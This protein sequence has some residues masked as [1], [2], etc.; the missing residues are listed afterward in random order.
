MIEDIF[1]DSESPLSAF[2]RDPEGV[3]MNRKAGFI[4]NAKEYAGAPAAAALAKAGWDVFC[5]DDSFAS[6]DM[7]AAYERDN[8]G[9]YAAAAQDAAAFISEG[10]ERFG[11]IDA[12]ISNDIPKGT[13]L[14][15]GRTAG[16]ASLESSDLL[17]E[18]EKH[19]DSLVVEPV[20]LLQAALPMM[21]AARAGSIV[22]ITSGAPLRTPAMGG[23]HGYTAA[24]AA[25][26]MLAKSLAGE[27]ARYNIQ[28]NAVAPFLVYSETFFPSELG[29]EDPKFASFVK[30]LVPMQRFGAPE[31]IGTLIYQLASGDMSFVSGQV[32]AFSGAGC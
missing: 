9:R 12:L 24:R 18:F 32:I 29:A 11:R 19:L 17:E 27:L 10:F 30:K 5:H 2:H 15:K 31:E 6:P 3:K 16:T 20:R 23:P 14:L 4:T 21:K 1:I 25:T 13:R 26:N 22:L 7:R 28:V 8:P